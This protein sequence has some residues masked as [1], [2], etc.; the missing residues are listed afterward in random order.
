MVI[1]VI[2][3]PSERCVVVGL[4]K[5]RLVEGEFLYEQSLS[6]E[7]HITKLVHATMKYMKYMKYTPNC[8]THITTSSPN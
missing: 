5:S 1:G 6:K 8:E 2:K 3:I 7:G 4:L